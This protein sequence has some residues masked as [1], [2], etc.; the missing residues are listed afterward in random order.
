MTKMVI[1]FRDGGF[2]VAADEMQGREVCRL[3]SA[4]ARLRVAL[5]R[6][7][8][9]GGQHVALDGVEGLQHLH[10]A[11]A[12]DAAAYHDT[13]VVAPQLHGQDAAAAADRHHAIRHVGS[14]AAR[15]A[16]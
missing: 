12:V 13:A 8:L 6:A 1:Y 16:G 9:Q 7:L 14:R 4:I 11:A 5:N 10:G 15:Q 2:A 3:L